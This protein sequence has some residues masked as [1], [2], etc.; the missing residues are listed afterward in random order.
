MSSMNDFEFYHSGWSK[1]RWELKYKGQDKDMVIPQA[2]IAQAEGECTV[3]ISAED[4]HEIESISIPNNVADVWLGT[5][6]GARGLKRITVDPENPYLKDVDGVLYAKDGKKLM[7]APAQMTGTY[8]VPDG[9]EELE[10]F[11]FQNSHFDEIILPDSLK[12][13]GSS[14]FQHS[15]IK[16]MSVP[17]S[18]TKIEDNVFC[19]CPDLEAFEFCGDSTI[20]YIYSD[21]YLDSE[22]EQR[23][24]GEAFTRSAECYLL[25]CLKIYPN[26]DKCRRK[27]IAA[28]KRGKRETILDYLLSTAPV[29]NVEKGTFEINEL[30]DGS[31]EIKSYQGEESVIEIPNEMDGKTITTI[32]VGAFEGNEFVEK[33]IVPEGV[34]WVQNKAFMGCVSL[35]EVVLPES[36]TAIGASVFEDCK[37]LK[38]A[39]LPKGVRVLASKVFKNCISLESLDIPDGVIKI[40]N[41][42]L[43]YC[44]SL[45][46]ITLP[47]GLIYLGKECLYA[48]GFNYGPVLE[49]EWGYSKRKLLIPASVTQID[50]G[51]NGI[52]AQYPKAQELF[53]V[54]E[55]KVI[56]QV[57]KGSIAHRYAAKKKIRF[58]LV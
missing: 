34:T 8:V 37:T 38:K 9:V 18:I 51:G 19:D 52:F 7:K 23:I 29:R 45:H 17:K 14:A 11:A 56:L 58:E 53:G 46:D 1:E 2:L 57:K 41:Q 13:I 5:L 25:A 33:V 22:M 16:K 42:A 35:E 24:S 27:F 40:E 32:G 47:E 20:E 49:G 4:P 39:D 15:S 48:C 43:Y 12:K 3:A 30:E 28:A 6:Y 44:E 36:C 26:I 55:Y 31:A 21:R 10:A 50:D 54:F